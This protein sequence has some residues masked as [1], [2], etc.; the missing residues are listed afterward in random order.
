MSEE[1]I[2][3]LD[4]G[5][6]NTFNGELLGRS[7]VFTHLSVSLDGLSTIRAFGAEDILVREFDNQQDTHTACWYMFIS[8]S[9][10]FGFTLDVMCFVFVFVVTFSFLLIDTGMT[11]NGEPA[12]E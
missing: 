2:L 3:H 10:A 1:N 12:P 7:P 11:L 4:F 5:K 6:I 9:S 8:A